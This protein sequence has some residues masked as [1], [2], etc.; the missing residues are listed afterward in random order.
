MRT[1]RSRMAR[2]RPRQGHRSS[3][4]VRY[5]RLVYLETLA[6]GLERVKNTDERLGRAIPSIR[7]ELTVHAN[8][9]EIQEHTSAIGGAAETYLRAKAGEQENL[10]NLARHDLVT[11]TR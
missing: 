2:R 7:R 5:R 6:V 1:P 4:G 10:I 9:T 3:F 11:R 8:F